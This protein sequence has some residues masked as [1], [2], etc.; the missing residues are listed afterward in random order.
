MAKKKVI[1]P[2]KRV[3]AKQ[4]EK[5]TRTAIPDDKK[6]VLHVG[7]MDGEI[8][9]GLDNRFIGDEWF[10]VRSGF[11]SESKVQTK[12]DM[13]TL[14]NFKTGQFDAIW[15]PGKLDRF[16]EKDCLTVCKQFRRVLKEGGAL[17]VSTPNIKVVCEN[18]YKNGI[19]HKFHTVNNHAMTP[20]DLIFGFQPDIMNGI[21]SAAHKIAFTPHA[22]LSILKTAG[23]KDCKVQADGLRLWGQG[24]NLKSGVASNPN[25]KVMGDDPN[26]MMKVRDELDTPT[27]LPVLYSA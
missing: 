27:A 8:H 16:N 12:E 1:K 24:L 22:L 4:A 13:L 3:L 14:A 19:K 10:E 7:C 11:E 23:F 17:L 26:E 18:V 15:F 2:S 20:M 21:S 9:K 5:K 25:G 6:L